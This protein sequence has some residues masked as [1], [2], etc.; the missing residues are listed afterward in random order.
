MSLIR[1]FHQSGAARL[2]RESDISVA[3]LSMERAENKT[4][5]YTSAAGY[6]PVGL[7][8]F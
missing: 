4:G 2:A 7:F 5:V 1:S 8:F 6:V 3:E